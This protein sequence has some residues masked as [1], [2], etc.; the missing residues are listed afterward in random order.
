MSYDPEVPIDP[1]RRRARGTFS[2]AS[3]RFEKLERTEVHDGWDLEEERA[4]FRTHLEFETAK[5]IITRNASPDLGFDRSINPYRGCEHGCVYCFARPTHA[6]M[7]F[8]PGLDFETQIMAKPDA[9][10]L[11]EKELRN[12]RYAVA[13]IAIGTNTDPY[14]PT[15]KTQRIMREC[16]EVLKAFKHPVGIVTKGT[17]IERD[18][19][20]LGDMARDRL[21]KVGVS[22]TSL[23]LKLSRLMEPRAPAPARRLKVIERLSA[24]GVPVRLMVSPVVPG[25]TDHEV[26][27]IIGAGAAAGA[28]AASWIMLRLPLEVSALFQEWLSVH[29]PDRRSKVMSLI[30]DMHGGQDYSSDWGKRMRGEGTYAQMIAH[31]VAIAMRRTGLPQE[32]PPL[33]CD[34]FE[35]PLAAGDQLSLF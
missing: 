31:R 26:E 34:L 30:R 12:R 32:L 28:Q 16:L 20:I 6:Y 27:R 2:N 29:F 13:P 17:L 33:R 22:V 35:R 15:E 11:L 19:D 4:E 25:L 3:G 5:T 9:A 23:D 7:G 1:Q 21:V 8:S 18:L 14:Q 10:E 24:A